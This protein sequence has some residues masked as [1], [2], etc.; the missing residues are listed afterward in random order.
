MLVPVPLHFLLAF[1]AGIA[2]QLLLPVRPLPALRVPLDLVGL[3]LL[4]AGGLLALASSG[5][6]LLART[7]ILPFD[8]A[9]SLVTRGPY[10]FS[11]NPM[12]ISAV[13]TYVGA[14]VH[15]YQFWSLLL[16]PLPL[17]LLA[18]FIV[19]REELRLRQIFGEPYELY[20]RRVRRW[21]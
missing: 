18:K 2:L 10:R 4:D 13:L 14:A 15:Y 6:F 7:S 20:C 1:A 3:Y 16:L 8:T 11:R 17:L 9:S 12:Y 21:L 5:L 19:P